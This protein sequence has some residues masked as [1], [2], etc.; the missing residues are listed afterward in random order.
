MMSSGLVQRKKARED[1][2]ESATADQDLGFQQESYGNGQDLTIMEEIVLL[3]LKDSE[4]K[5]AIHLC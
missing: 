4:V 3:G 1:E 2:E 5:E